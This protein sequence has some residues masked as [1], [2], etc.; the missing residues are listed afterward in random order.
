MT[1]KE[2][3]FKSILLSWVFEPNKRTRIWQSSVLMSESTSKN[4]HYA[5]L[6]HSYDSAPNNNKIMISYGVILREGESLMAAYMASICS[7]NRSLI[8]ARLYFMVAV[9][10]LFSMQKGSGWSV[11]SLTFKQQHQ[12]KD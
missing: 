1:E 5:P 7:W 3:D 12:Q 9:S 6:H 4:E 8:A 2:I 11:N 10:R